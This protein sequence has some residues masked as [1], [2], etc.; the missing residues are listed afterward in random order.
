MNSKTT[1][2]VAG[3]C[4]SLRRDSV[5]RKVLRLA[6]GLMPPGM[7]MHTVEISD[8]PMYNFDLHQNGFPAPVVRV[9]DEIKRADAIFFATPEHNFSMPAALKNVIDWMSRF[10]PT[11]LTNKPCAVIS[12]S[13]GQLGGARV[14][15]DLRRSLGFLNALVMLQPEVFVGSAHTKFD[16]DGGFTDDAGREIIKQHMAAFAD[17]IARMKVAFPPAA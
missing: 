9:H 2:S 11:P 3:I 1:F 17:W 7:T 8:L 4:G 5:N 16:A 14:Q 12:A 13:P 15:Y 6:E 10:R